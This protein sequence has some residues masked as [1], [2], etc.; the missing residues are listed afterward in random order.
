[1]LREPRLIGTISIQYSEFL[2]E[3]S[4]MALIIVPAVVSDANKTRRM[5]MHVLFT[6]PC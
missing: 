6:Q 5:V 1:M 4:G 2:V 3:M